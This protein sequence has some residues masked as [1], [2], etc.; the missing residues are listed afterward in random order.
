MATRVA[1]SYFVM[2]DDQ[3]YYLNYI[4]NAKDFEKYLPQFEQMVKSFKFV[5]IENYFR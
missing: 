2:H 4:A 3:P 5:N 1:M